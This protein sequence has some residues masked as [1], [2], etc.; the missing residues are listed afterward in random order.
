MSYSEFLLFPNPYYDVTALKIIH[1]ISFRNY[2]NHPIKVLK[3]KIT[4][5]KH[6]AF[7]KRLPTLHVNIFV[8]NVFNNRNLPQKQEKHFMSRF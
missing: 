6:V 3:I 4:S 8:A 1:P 2:T 5:C 7:L